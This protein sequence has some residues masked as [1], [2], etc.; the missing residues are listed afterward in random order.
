MSADQGIIICAGVEKI[1]TEV[2][3]RTSTPVAIDSPRGTSSWGSGRGIGTLPICFIV[4]ENVDGSIKNLDVEEAHRLLDESFG[5][6]H[7]GWE[8]DFSLVD[9]LGCLLTL[10]T[11]YFVAPN[12]GWGWSP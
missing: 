6:D 3:A 10:W 5:G 2:L 12:S 9:A 7:L 4:R 8:R 11:A 1:P